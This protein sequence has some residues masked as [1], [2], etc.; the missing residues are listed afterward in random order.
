MNTEVEASIKIRL[1][2]WFDPS[3]AHQHYRRSEQ[4]FRHFPRSSVGYVSDL[5]ATVLM[6]Q[7][8]RRGVPVT[9]TS[10]VPSI[11]PCPVD[12]C[13][14]AGSHAWSDLYPM[15]ELM[16]IHKLVTLDVP[17][18]YGGRNLVVAAE[19]HEDGE[20]APT[21]GVEL[22]DA[23]SLQSWEQVRQVVGAMIAAA[24]LAFGPEVHNLPN[25]TEA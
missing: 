4:V 24:E 6:A 11:T 9:I 14:A 5:K 17:N 20:D 23:D 8:Q 19:V 1:G 21:P 10:T 2:Y 7:T 16:R 13:P 15:P 12:W 25:G 18:G 3:I 22:Y